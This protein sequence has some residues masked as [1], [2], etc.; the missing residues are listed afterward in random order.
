MD[1]FQ[2]IVSWFCFMVKQNASLFMTMLK[3]NKKLQFMVINICV[4]CNIAAEIDEICLKSKGGSCKKE[5][6]LSIQ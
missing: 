6:S 1:G 4:Y 3:V 2:M 5:S